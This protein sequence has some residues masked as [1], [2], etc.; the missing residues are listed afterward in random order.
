M[1]DFHSAVKRAVEMVG[2][3]SKLAAAAGCSQAE[4][5]RLCNTAKSVDPLIACRIA[6]AT[7]GEVTVRDLIPEV[8][9]VVSAELQREAGAA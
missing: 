6:E 2:G 7:N 8:V 4:I 9:D 3:Q 1:K 5:W